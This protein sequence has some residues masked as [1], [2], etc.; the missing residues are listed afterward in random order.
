MSQKTEMFLDFQ[1]RNQGT[2]QTNQTNYCKAGVF[3]LL[4]KGLQLLLRAGSRAARGKITVIGTPNCLSYCVIFTIYITYEC[5]R[6]LRNAS[7]RAT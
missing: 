4:G 7:W 1:L 3:N 6:G 5:G 2:K